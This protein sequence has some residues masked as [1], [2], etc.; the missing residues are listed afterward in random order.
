ME[1]SLSTSSHFYTCKTNTSCIAN[2]AASI[3]CKNKSLGISSTRIWCVRHFTEC[4]KPPV[5][6][7]HLCILA[8]SKHISSGFLRAHRSPVLLTSSRELSKLAFTHMLHWFPSLLKVT[9]RKIRWV[10][11][12]FFL[13]LFSLSP[14]FVSLFFFSLRPDMFMAQNRQ[15]NTVGASD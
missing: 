13:F 11:I 15:K 7:L 14:F 10:D 2:Y 9:Q 6:A 8:T 4:C 12:S 1:S 5:K 3:M